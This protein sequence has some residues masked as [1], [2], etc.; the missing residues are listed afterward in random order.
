VKRIEVREDETPVP[1]IGWLDVRPQVMVLAPY[2]RAEFAVTMRIP[3]APEHFGKLYVAA[4]R[5]VSK[6]KGQKPV[7]TTNKVRAVVPS[8]TGWSATRTGGAGPPAK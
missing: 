4:L 7:E 8:L 2:S 1:D 3:I 6:R 5:T